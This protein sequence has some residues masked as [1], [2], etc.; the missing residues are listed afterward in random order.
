MS[1]D[2]IR[3]YYGVPAKKGARVEAYGK[4]GVITGASGP[5]ILIRLDGHKNAHPYHP[6]DGI[7]YAALRAEQQKEKDNG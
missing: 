6:T 2:Y 5:H 4:P 7:E 1:L 3:S